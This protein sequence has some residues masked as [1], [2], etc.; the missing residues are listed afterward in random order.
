[1]CILRD[2]ECMSSAHA[3]IE[4]WAHALLKVGWLQRLNGIGAPHLRVGQT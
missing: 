2:A 3:C 1:M 4:A